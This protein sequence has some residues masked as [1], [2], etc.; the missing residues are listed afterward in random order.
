[1]YLG[2][3]WTLG[4]IWAGVWN[5]GVLQNVASVVVV[6]L[7][8]LAWAGF[9]LARRVRTVYWAGVAIALVAV[10]ML[11]WDQLVTRILTLRA[12]AF[13]LAFAVAA[14]IL[15]FWRGLSAESRG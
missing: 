15:I 10:A 1:M 9:L 12:D 7:N 2:V 13:H 6:A 5:D 3:S 11:T 8:L 14:L 4:Y